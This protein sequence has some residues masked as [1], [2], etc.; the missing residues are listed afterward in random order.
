MSASRSRA[1][2]GPS[3]VGR[4][5]AEAGREHDLVAVQ[6]DRR[7]QSLQH[8]LSD[9]LGLDLHVA[10][11]VDE[12]REL[13]TAET[14]HGVATAHHPEQPSRDVLQETITGLVAQSVVHVLEAVEVDVDDP[15]I[16][17]CPCAARQRVLDPVTEERPVRQAGQR[18]VEGLVHELLLRLLPIGDVVDV[19]HHAV[20]RR[21]VQ[22][23]HRPRPEPELD[24]VRTSHTPLTRQ[25]HAW[26]QERC[27]EHPARFHVRVGDE[28]ERAHTG[29]GRTRMTHQRRERRSVV[30]DEAVGVEQQHGVRGVRRQRAV[31]PLTSLDVR[32]GLVAQVEQA[33]GTCGCQRHEERRADDERYRVGVGPLDVRDEID[34]AR[35]EQ[36]CDAEGDPHRADLHRTTGL[37][38]APR[39]PV[40]APARA[41]EQ[42]RTRHPADVEQ[43]RDHTVGHPQQE[44]EVR[45]QP[46][47]DACRQQ[48]A[49]VGSRPTLDHGAD[50]QHEERAV[51][52]R[53]GRPEA[54]HRDPDRVV[55]ERR[56][57]HELP[58][59]ERR[60]ERCD[61]DVDQTLD[62]GPLAAPALAEQQEHAQRDAC[63]GREP[64]DI[65]DRGVR[66][67][68][69]ERHDH[70]EQDVARGGRD[71]AQRE[72]HAD[73][74]AEPADAPP[75]HGARAD[76][77]TEVA[78]LPQC[79]I[80][81]H[82]VGSAQTDQGGRS[83]PAEPSA[84]A[85]DGLVPR[86]AL[87]CDHIQSSAR[88]VA[89]MSASST[90][91]GLTG[92]A[93]LPRRQGSGGQEAPLA[94]GGVPMMY[95]DTS[96]TRCVGPLLNRH[97]APPGPRR[98]MTALGTVCPAT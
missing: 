90:R 8:A 48:H 75:G 36:R 64:R 5:D 57:E 82:E 55:G 21:V 2:A 12:D 98:A 35:D 85:T 83:D 62:V 72:R 67:A 88:C 32:A 29:R 26:R 42:C 56:V 33:D 43:P 13:V 15:R 46:A 95:A 27:V 96:T 76:G 31:Q 25:H 94:A 39:R 74:A 10:R 84:D 86:H 18:V 1:E 63:V 92:P 93:P 70:L 80:P 22:Q 28:V 60:S 59:H 87:L 4:G 91:S 50:H 17:R 14:G 79:A 65:C 38:H 49:H 78:R 53:I 9:R 47:R 54:T 45:D 7:R 89:T 69:P 52:H 11:L 51:E 81:P 61:G 16:E 71:D 66:L 19:D 73:P 24:T 77:R 20:H 41:G 6:G 58:Q 68:A 34:G 40:V 23:V 44:P 3:V 97:T 37:G 30:H